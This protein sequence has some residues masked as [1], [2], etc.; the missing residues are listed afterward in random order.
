[1][2]DPM[3]YFLCALA[4]LSA[5]PTFADNEKYEGACKADVEKYC[6]DIQP[7]ERRI[8]HCLAAHEPNL[9]TECKERRAEVKE[10]TKEFMMA[11]KDDL[12]KHCK[13]TKRGKGRKVACL[14]ENEATLN[15]TCK[16]ELGDMQ[17]LKT[18]KK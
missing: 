14:K 16:N 18:Q 7:G 1:M 4:L 15:E 10:A 5:V 12:M 9:S 6:K 3:K 17:A 8:A 2:E 13:G 11:C